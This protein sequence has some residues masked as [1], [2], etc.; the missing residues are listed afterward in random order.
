MA[1][2]ITQP[3]PV[4]M[5][6]D[7]TPLNNG[8]IYIGT[9]NLNPE[10]NPVACYW[11]IN[12][13]LPAAQP[14]RTVNGLPSRNGNPST[15]YTSSSYSIT[16][17][18]I[19]SEL[20]F[21]SPVGFPISIDSSAISFIQAGAGA[22]QT[23]VRTKLREFVTAKSDYGVA[24]DGITDDTT[25]LQ[26][27]ID[28]MNSAG[29][30]DVI[31]PIGTCL[32]TGLTLKS[33][34]RLIGKG[35]SRT[36]LKNT[37]NAVGVT[38]NNI[39]GHGMRDLTISQIGNINAV[40]ALS[41]TD[42]SNAVYLD[43]GIDT[44]GRYGVAL[45]GGTVSGCFQNDFFH[46]D[47]INLSGTKRGIYLQKNTNRNNANRFIGGRV[48]NGAYGVYIDT[49]AGFN[50]Q[51]MI[52]AQSQTSSCVYSD[53]ANN[54]FNDIYIETSSAGAHG[55]DLGVNASGTYM[56]PRVITVSGGGNNINAP[57]GSP[58]SAAPRYIYLP[59]TQIDTA[60]FE[61]VACQSLTVDIGSGSGTSIPVARASIAVSPGANVG[62]GATLV[63][64]YTLPANS[65]T[66]S[67]AGLRITTTGTTSNAGVAKTVQLYVD[68]GLGTQAL[69]AQVSS[70][71]AS[72]LPWMVEAIIMR[73]GASS[74]TGFS[75]S[76][77]G[78]GTSFNTIDQ[79]TQSTSS[80][81]TNA[82]TIDL[83]LTG[84]SN[85]DVTANQWLVE[86]IQ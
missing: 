60:R 54:S 11:D 79:R 29:G 71:T 52:T 9:A 65:I 38:V 12:L 25:K 10:T 67:A 58:I 40:D 86:V 5:D 36:I 35:R 62:A 16:V 8:Y 18:N 75:R 15:I 63:K 6:T 13:T 21:T 33:N 30:G 53:S 44:P 7:G 51:F 27:A 72:I 55:F 41:I 69:I 77:M 37:N 57:A 61:S 20:V 42:S 26:A 81:W 4:F 1:N 28:D 73:T 19:R 49:D 74:G 2:Q 24:A 80:T 14:I 59:P 43:I 34:V 47:I 17:R 76:T 32:H 56:A 50:N 68:Y 3:Y 64:S 22:V 45:L 78:S 39:S 23:D 70:S 66:S 82:I 83:V 84:T 31:L 85:G 46:I 48:N